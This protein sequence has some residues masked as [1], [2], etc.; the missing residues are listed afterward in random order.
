MQI[1]KPSNVSVKTNVP[2]SEDAASS[3]E[4][5]I[6]QV[7]AQ[8]ALCSVSLYKAFGVVHDCFRQRDLK[9]CYRSWSVGQII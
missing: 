6:P 7:T 5:Q 2:F 8:A 9:A 4:L 3:V 1:V